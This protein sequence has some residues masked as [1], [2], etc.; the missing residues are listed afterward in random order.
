MLF[1]LPWEPERLLESAVIP[2]QVKRNQAAAFYHRLALLAGKKPVV[3]QVPVSKSI[4][5]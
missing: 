1:P 3:L 5:K 2:V 4:A